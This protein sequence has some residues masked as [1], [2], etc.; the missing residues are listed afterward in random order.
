MGR[1]GVSY[2]V[3]LQDTD[4]RYRPGI[5]I[6]NK[7]GRAVI[8]RVVES[9]GIDLWNMASEQEVVEAGDE[10]MSVNGVLDRTRF[11]K[12][13]NADGHVMIVLQKP[14]KHTL[15]LDKEDSNLGIAVS[16]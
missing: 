15:H 12:E 3:E 9:G 8:T 11:L 2:S 1:E 10:I 7:F 14:Y 4:E 6:Q 13:L 5:N 16:V